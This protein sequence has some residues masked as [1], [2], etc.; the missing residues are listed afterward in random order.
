MVAA[1]GVVAAALSL[2]ALGRAGAVHD[3]GSA[4]VLSTQE[5]ALPRLLSETGLYDQSGRVASRNL[6]F[7]PQYPL[8]TDGAAKLRWIYLP[9][10]ETIDIS[11]IDIWKFPVGTKLWKEF[12]W[13][14]RRVETRFIWR[15]SEESWVFGTYVWN[16]EQ[17]EAVLAP[18][19]GLAGAAEI[20]PG[21]FHT[22]PGL[23][24]CRTCHQSSPSVV[25]GF[26][27]LQLSDD[28]DPLAPH[29]EPEQPAGLTLS[30]L[31]ASKLLSPPRPDLVEKPPRIRA[32]SSAARAAMGYLSANCGGCHNQTGPLARLGLNLL[33]MVGAPDQDPEPAMLSALTTRGRFVLPGMSP[34]SCGPVVPG[35]P[36]RST[37]PYR[38][39]SRRPSSQMPPLGT[40][41]VDQEAVAIIEQ[42]IASI[43]SSARPDSSR[44]SIARSD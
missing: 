26:N 5:I 7:V 16:D 19:E 4:S 21:M 44:R 33:H 37:I 17:T 1:V 42:W 11:D 22:I 38:M 39:K 8:W 40:V 36:Q 31:M 41:L 6:P 20:A 23:A 34:D 30:T 10:G 15:A 43:D 25:L 28:R 14:D 27:A 12:A 35:A 9:P 29:R 3:P 2:V 24:D 32:S 18:E 13:A